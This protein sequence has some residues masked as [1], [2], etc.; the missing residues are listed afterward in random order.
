MIAWRIIAG[1]DTHVEHKTFANIPDEFVR[2]NTLPVHIDIAVSQ[3]LDKNARGWRIKI[4]HNTSVGAGGKTATALPERVVVVRFV[5]A[6][7]RQAFLDFMAEQL[8]LRTPAPDAAQAL[9]V[10]NLPS[11]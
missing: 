6:R 5:T 7:Q 9:Q 1:R 11:E 2:W 8:K 10:S 3:W 4:P